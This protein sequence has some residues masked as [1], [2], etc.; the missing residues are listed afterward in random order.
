M[1]L[2]YYLSW[3]YVS[4]ILS[5]VVI[6]LWFFTTV[7]GSQPLSHVNGVS[8][9]VCA[10][11]DS[12]QSFPIGSK[13]PFSEVSSPMSSL[14]STRSLGWKYMGLAFL[15]HLGAMTCLKSDSVR[16]T[17][18]LLLSKKFR[19]SLISCELSSPC[20]YVLLHLIFL[21]RRE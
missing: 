2:F 20:G 1:I 11:S 7:L 6:V 12:V 21:P 13:F 10:S 9:L 8:S 16:A 4:I 15:L 17:N 5:L 3:Y 19:S 14:W 18:H